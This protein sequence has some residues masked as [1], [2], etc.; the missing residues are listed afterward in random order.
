ME[1][2][3]LMQTHK[4]D[5]TLPIVLYG[6]SYW[7]EVVNLEALVHHGMIDRADLGLFQFADDPKTAF[8]IL[9]ARLA[10]DPAPVAPEY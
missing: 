2:L 10:V 5:R 6:S 8:E 1:I 7:N 9:R 3:T 4:I